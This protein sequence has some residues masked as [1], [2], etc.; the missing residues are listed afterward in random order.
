[1]FAASSVSLA[2]LF[3][4]DLKKKCCLLIGFKK[5]QNLGFKKLDC[6]IIYIASL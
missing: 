3:T 1:M 5:E 2:V 6:C 4:N